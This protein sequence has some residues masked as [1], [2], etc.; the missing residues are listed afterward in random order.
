M[1]R[2]NSEKQPPDEPG[3]ETDQNH[4]WIN[5]LDEEAEMEDLVW[6]DWTKEECEVGTCL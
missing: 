1:W 3:A 4:N 6:K 5:D 2:E